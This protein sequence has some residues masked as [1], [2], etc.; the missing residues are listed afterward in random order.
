MLSRSFD[1]IIYDIVGKHG[2]LNV[3]ELRKLEKLHVKQNKAKNDIN[4]L[5]NC[6]RFYVFNFLALM[7]ESFLVYAKNYRKMLCANQYVKREISKKHQF[8]RNTD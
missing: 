8:F 2:N 5:K 7:G 4:F 6:K 3:S 1:K